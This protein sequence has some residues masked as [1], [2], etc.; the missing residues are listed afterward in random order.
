MTFE[1]R[2]SNRRP[3]TKIFVAFV[4][5]EGWGLHTQTT[6]EEKASF[7]RGRDRLSMVVH[8]NIHLT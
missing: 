3:K 4:A 2:S 6:K 8:S 7:M 1:S 5:G